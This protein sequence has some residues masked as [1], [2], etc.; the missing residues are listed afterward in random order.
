LAAGKGITVGT[1]PSIRAGAPLIES[2][3]YTVT[4]AWKDASGTGYVTLRNPWGFDGAGQDSNPGDA[5]V[6]MTIDQLQQNIDGGM[7]F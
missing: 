3:Q 5:L 2:H 1:N 7:V 6:T 4:N